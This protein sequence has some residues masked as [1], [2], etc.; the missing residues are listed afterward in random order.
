MSLLLASSLPSVGRVRDNTPPPSLDEEAA[1][2]LVALMWPHDLDSVVSGSLLE[3]L[4][5]RYCIPEEFVLVAP[6]P[7]QR[8]YDPIPRGFALTLDALEAGLRLPLH[9]VI[10]SCLSL[11]RISPSQV[12]PNSWRYLVAFLGECYYANITPTRNLFVSCFRL[13]KGL[14]RYFL[15]ARTDNAAPSLNDEERRDLE[16]LREILPGSQAIRAMNEQWLAEAGLSSASQ[17]MRLLSLRGGQSSSAS[18]PRP[19]ADPLPGSEDAPLEVLEGRPSKKAKVAIPEKAKVGPTKPK[20]AVEKRSLVMGELPSGEATDPLVAR[21]EGLSRGDKVWAG[22]DPSASFLRGVLH[23]DMARDLYTLP[24]EAL[25]SKSAKSL[26]LGLH[27]STALMDRVCDAGQVICDLS[28]RNSELCRQEKLE[29]SENSGKELQRLLRLDRAE[30]R[31]LKSEALT[32]TKKAEKAEAEARAAFGALA[33][34]TRLRPVKDKEAIE[35]YKKSEGFELGLIR[36]GRV[37]YEYGYKVALGRFR[38][39]PPDSEVE[40]DPFSSHPEDRKVDMPE[41]VPFDDRP[42]TP[43]E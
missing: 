25:L 41:D 30:L 15:L 24:S 8:V 19:P 9:P 11:W 42:R 4:R 20:V 3:T 10:V 29:K 28:E 32:L 2:A 14:G 35:A 18:S 37:S 21:W 7:G 16:R 31:L 17:E 43:E 39:L 38:A 5:E 33:E 6:D 13:F 1:R 34:E 40:E 22:G 23:P 12:A 27:Y 36:M 26:T